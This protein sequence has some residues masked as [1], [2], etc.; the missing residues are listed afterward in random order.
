MKMQTCLVHPSDGLTE[1]VVTASHSIPTIS[2]PYHV[3]I[4]VLAVA[5]N[6]TDYRM[7]AYNPV[8]GAVLGCDFVGIALEAGPQAAT[9]SPG[10]RV[11]GTVHGC[12][13]AN[14]NNGAFAEYLVA[15]ARVLLRVPNTWSDLQGAAL[16]GVGW[17]TV[18]LA[19]ED[20]LKLTG[21]PS[22]P[23]QPRA[24]GSRVPVMVYGGATATG[25]MACQILTSSGYDAIA[26]ASSASSTLVKGFG[27]TAVFAYTSPTCGEMVQKATSGSLKHVIDCI[28]SPDSVACCF[29]ALA[30]AGARYASLDYALPEWRT[31]KSVKV[32]MPLAYTF[33]GTEVKLRDL[34][35]READPTKLEL[36]VRWRHEIQMLLDGGQLKCHPVREVP[37]RWNGIINGLQMLKAGEVRGQKLVVRIAPSA[38]SSP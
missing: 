23:A 36:A 34:Y 33:W 3:L 20:C 6:P 35:Y 10:M 25:T 16:G 8:P 11:C 15:D 18:A 2:E 12:N 38:E 13:P 29:T 4:R 17:A 14:P 9:C 22:R 30:R 1:P 28:T 27:A 31:R 32:D 19:M 37:G 5:L 7:P 26:T 24:D 21:R